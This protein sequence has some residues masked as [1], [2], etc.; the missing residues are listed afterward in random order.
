MIQ[1]MGR[2]LQKEIAFRTYHGLQK[3]VWG[4]S[5]PMAG[6]DATRRTLDVTVESEKL[7]TF[8]RQLDEKNVTTAVEN[9]DK[10]FK[11]QM[12]R[13]T[14]ENMY[15]PV[16]KL[17][18]KE[19]APYTTRVKVSVSEKYATNIWI[20]KEGEG[21]S[22][23]YTKGTHNDLTKDAKMMII[24]ESTGLWFMSKQFGCS[25]NATRFI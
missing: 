8:L 7:L 9:C 14:I 23:E 19:G 10:W 21:N 4:L 3:A 5:S 24:V 13:T 11:R 17:P 25:M 16:V 1:N 22:L 20:V 15:V 2:S 18:F 12:D 6:S